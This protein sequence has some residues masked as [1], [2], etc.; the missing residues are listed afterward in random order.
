VQHLRQAQRTGERNPLRERDRFGALCGVN[1]CSTTCG[2]AHLAIPTHHDTKAVYQL[3]A[4]AR[5]RR[6]HEG[7]EVRSV[8]AA[9]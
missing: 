8:H 2:Y 9:E 3:L 4:T 7:E 5:E 1:A 6:S